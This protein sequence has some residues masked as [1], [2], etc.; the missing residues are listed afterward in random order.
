MTVYFDILQQVRKQL[1]STFKNV[2]LFSKCRQY[3]GNYANSLNSFS[4]YSYFTSLL[5]KINLFTN[6]T[7]INTYALTT[8]NCTSYLQKICEK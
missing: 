7:N 5:K 2:F 1:S 3:S 8:L 4:S 6:F